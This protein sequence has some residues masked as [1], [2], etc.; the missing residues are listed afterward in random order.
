MKEDR[1]QQVLEIEK[2]ARE[3]HA[4]AVREAEQLIKQADQ[5][6]QKLIEKA[7]SEAKD[8]ARQIVANAQAKDEIERILT[9]TEDEIKR[10]KNLAKGNLDRAISYVLDRVAGRE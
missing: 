3:I 4:A 8:E 1:I 9:E 2:Q 10:S 7:N 5:E 6:A